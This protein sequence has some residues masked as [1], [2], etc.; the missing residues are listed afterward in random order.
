MNK[1]YI[2]EHEWG[3]SL[4][5]AK[6]KLDIWY[7]KLSDTESYKFKT[8]CPKCGTWFS[9]IASQNL[10]LPKAIADYMAFYDKYTIFMECKKSKGNR[11]P[12]RNIKEHQWRWAIQ[13]SRFPNVKYYFIIN[14]RRVP[15]NY[16]CYAVDIKTFD[17]IAVTE[18]KMSLSW[19]QIADNSIH[20]DRLY[21]RVW[22]AVKFLEAISNE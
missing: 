15:R 17:E 8:I 14:D 12:F 16:K 21:G 11:F 2:F 5:L 20:V 10:I 6:Q 19:K 9:P 1:G 4:K 13:L 22:D 18:G 3:E 7:I